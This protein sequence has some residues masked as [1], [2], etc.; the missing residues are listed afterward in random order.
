M[1]VGDDVFQCW[2]PA[3]A[4]AAKRPDMTAASTQP[5]LKPQSV[6]SPAMV[7]LSYELSRGE[8]RDSPGARQSENVAIGRVDVCGP[9]L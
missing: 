5:S 6:Q 9:E 4:C 1:I 8:I 3:I 7:R 2:R